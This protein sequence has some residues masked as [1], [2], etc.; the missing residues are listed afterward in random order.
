V[1]KAYCAQGIDRRAN[2]VTIKPTRKFLNNGI[3]PVSTAN[4]L[5]GKELTRSLPTGA[6]CL[7]ERLTAFT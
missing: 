7:R 1:A 5:A 4:D 3:A 6:R 2:S